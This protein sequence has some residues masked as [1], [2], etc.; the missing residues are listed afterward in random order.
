MTLSELLT[1]LAACPGVPAELAEEARQAAQAAATWRGLRAVCEA[2]GID[3]HAVTSRS[4]SASVVRQR[5]AL[6]WALHSEGWPWTRIGRMTGHHH[7]TVIYGVRQYLRQRDRAHAEAY[8]ASAPCH[9]VS[10]TGVSH[11]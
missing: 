7:A 10:S 11:G 3:Y 8:A 2:L 6:W 4:R 9:N 1:R 5:R